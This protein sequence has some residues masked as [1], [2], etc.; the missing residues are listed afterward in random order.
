[1]RL[2]RG[3]NACAKTIRDRGKRF[4]QVRQV[5]VISQSWKP[6]KSRVSGLF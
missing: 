1:V 4:M 5:N 2:E 3:G 6:Q